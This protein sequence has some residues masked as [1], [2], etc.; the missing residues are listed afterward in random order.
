MPCIVAEGGD[1]ATNGTWSA[2]LWA[3]NPV[4][5]A[6]EAAWL[7]W[8]HNTSLAANSTSPDGHTGA[9]D[10]VRCRHSRICEGAAACTA[11]AG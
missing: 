4:S 3:L 6:W 2:G 7:E 11:D 8:Q 9:D 1:E 10:S 5:L